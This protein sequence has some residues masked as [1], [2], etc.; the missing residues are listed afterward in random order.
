MLNFC[1]WAR[2]RFAITPDDCV[3][4][5][6]ALYF[7]NSVFDFCAS[8]FNGASLVPL[9]REMVTNPKQLVEATKQCSIWFSVPSLLIYVNTLK[10]FGENSWPHMRAIIFGGE[11]FPKAELAKLYARFGKQ[12][13]LWNVYGPTECTCICSAY[14]IS[15]QDLGDMQKLAPLG[16][17]AGIFSGAVI[18]EAGNEVAAGQVGELYLMG[19]QVARGYYNAP[20]L[21]R[22]AFAPY[23]NQPCYR[24]GDLVWQDAKTGYY[25]FA[26]RKDNQ[27]K[28]MGYRI[29]LEEIEAAAAGIE[30]VNQAAVIY[31]K[32]DAT[33]GRIIAFVSS[34]QELQP[35]V[36]QEKLRALLPSYMV[37][38]EVIIKTMLPK[39]ANG[40]IDRKAL[41]LEWG[42]S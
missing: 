23:Q 16:H 2:D 19:S 17:L 21:T 8:L 9:G 24:T 33:S 3:S 18:N 12:A 42:Q 34:N 36:L 4:G 15:E 11:G 1:D 31:H 26:G 28:H 38:H 39:N 7:D 10:A 30:A 22:A 29:E 13:T 37:P 6:N 32:G 40:K 35:I 41:A 14:A 5:A 25:H 20:E 27:I